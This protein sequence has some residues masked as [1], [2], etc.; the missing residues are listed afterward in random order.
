MFFWWL[1]TFIAFAAVL[2]T[3]IIFFLKRAEIRQ[4]SMELFEMVESGRV[5]QSS[6][7]LHKGANIE[8]RNQDGDTPLICAV[9]FNRPAIVKM[10]LEY[11]A[12]P[13]L[14]NKE[15]QIAM[16]LAKKE[17]NKEII[18]ILKRYNSYS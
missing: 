17:E 16:D 9:K 2:V 4:I 18:A 12:N 15:G 8:I 11:G 14:K 5:V 7:L 10:L 13:E 6:N 3:A 1:L